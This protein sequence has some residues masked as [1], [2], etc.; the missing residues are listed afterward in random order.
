MS[1]SDSD[2]MPDLIPVV[3]PNASPPFHHRK[4]DGD[5]E[6]DDLP[7][8]VRV[9][10]KSANCSASAKKNNKKK[11]KTKAAP[12]REQEEARNGGGDNNDEDAE[13]GSGDEMPK[14]ISLK[15]AQKVEIITPPKKGEAVPPEPKIKAAA[16]PFVSTLR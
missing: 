1:D 15:E 3:Q 7:A 13:D 4:G 11:V 10:R 6:L 8:L 12:K 16:P 9:G 14:L 5:S 2:E